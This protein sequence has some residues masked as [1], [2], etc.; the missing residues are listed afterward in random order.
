MVNL[1]NIFNA[2]IKKEIVK[3]FKESFRTEWWHFSSLL[4][5]IS[6]LY[7]LISNWS[8]YYENTI[9][10][11]ASPMCIFLIR[12]NHSL[13]HSSIMFLSTKMW[14]WCISSSTKLTM[15]HWINTWTPGI[16]EPWVILLCNW[17]YHQVSGKWPFLLF[18][19]IVSVAKF[20]NW[21]S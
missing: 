2:M 8:L 14:S 9:L 16:Y 13:Y 1:K 4:I 12:N 11:I 3:Q 20:W 21:Q 10:L 18:T 19:I 7:S 15:G 6:P 17:K 5:K